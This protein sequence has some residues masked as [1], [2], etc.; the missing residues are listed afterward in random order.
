[1]SVYIRGCNTFNKMVKRL[2]NPKKTMDE[3][4]T[5]LEKCGLRK[6]IEKFKNNF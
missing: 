1:M 5:N 4:L 3:V 6:S 2:K